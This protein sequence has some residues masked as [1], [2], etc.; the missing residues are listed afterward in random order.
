MSH[1]GFIAENARKAS[2]GLC[3]KNGLKKILEAEKL[4]DFL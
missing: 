2:K 4:L 3:D 1:S